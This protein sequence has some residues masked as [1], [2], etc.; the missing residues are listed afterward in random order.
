MGQSKPSPNQRPRAT[1]R[2]GRILHGIAAQPKSLA[3][4][5][6]V[7]VTTTKSAPVTW[8]AGRTTVPMGSKQGLLGTSLTVVRSPKVTDKYGTPYN[9]YFEIRTNKE[10]IN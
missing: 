6:R 3:T 5:L 4:R 9:Q 10:N 8:S 1:L 2:H 7:I